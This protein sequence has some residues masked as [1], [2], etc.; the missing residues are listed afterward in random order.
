[1][2][3]ATS[4]LIML[5]AALGRLFGAAFALPRPR[6]P[7]PS[8]R[9]PLCPAASVSAYTSLILGTRYEHPLAGV[10]GLIGVGYADFHAGVN[11]AITEFSEVRARRIRVASWRCG[12]G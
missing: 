8:P 3:F 5:L 7:K 1:M 10:T 4:A 11:F 2:S 9:P 12:K 6:C